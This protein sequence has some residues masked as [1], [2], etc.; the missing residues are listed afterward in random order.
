MKWGKKVSY[1]RQQHFGFSI[2]FSRVEISSL[3]QGNNRII[4]TQHIKI[5]QK[6]LGRGLEGLS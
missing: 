6:L 4:Y 2:T 3:F 1:L 5:F